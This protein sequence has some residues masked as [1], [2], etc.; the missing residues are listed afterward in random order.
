MVRDTRGVPIARWS[1]DE[2]AAVNADT[3]RIVL[4]EV[5][6]ESATSIIVTLEAEGAELGLVV[7]DSSG[8]SH[9]FPA[10]KRAPRPARCTALAIPKLPER[11]LGNRPS[12]PSST[13]AASDSSNGFD[14]PVRRDAHGSRC[15]ARCLWL[16][17][18]A[19]DLRQGDERPSGTSMTHAIPTLRYSGRHRTRG[20]AARS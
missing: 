15:L 5:A 13:A 19:L 8:T 17:C 18:E 3:V 10:D 2:A 1:K 6:A 7:G 14:R 16:I 9:L 11:T 20:H 4:A 12:Q